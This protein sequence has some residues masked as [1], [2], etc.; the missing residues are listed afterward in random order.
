ML[1]LFLGQLLLALQLSERGFSAVSCISRALRFLA[2]PVL[3]SGHWPKSVFHFDISWYSKTFASQALPQL[4]QC[5]NTPSS[6]VVPSPPTL[7]VQKVHPFKDT[8]PSAALSQ[9]NW[10][11]SYST[12]LSVSISCPSTPLLQSRGSFIQWN[13]NSE[14]LWQKVLLLPSL[15]KTSNK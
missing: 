6:A 8:L 13:S 11:C 15:Y 14:L 12:A 10:D 2:F 4:S 3:P 1:W 5:K 7:R 9:H